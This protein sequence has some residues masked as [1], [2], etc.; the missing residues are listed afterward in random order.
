MI[1]SKTIVQMQVYRHTDTAACGTI[2]ADPYGPDSICLTVAAGRSSA[3]LL[4]VPL[5]ELEAFVAA[6]RKQCEA[7]RWAGD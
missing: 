1:T 3:L 6:A 7:T 4:D 5:D 2:S